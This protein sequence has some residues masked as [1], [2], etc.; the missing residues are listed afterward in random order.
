MGVT[1]ADISWH[2]RLTDL[3]VA[4]TNA[5]DHDFGDVDLQIRPDSWTHKAAI[6]GDSLG[7]S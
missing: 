3:R 2:S 4:V 7:C 1:I 6:L 5:T